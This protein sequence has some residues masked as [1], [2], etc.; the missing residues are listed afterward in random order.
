MT[1]PYDV[2]LDTLARGRLPALFEREKARILENILDPNT[3]ATAKRQ[4]VVTI[5]FEPSAD[6]RTLT[7]TV[8]AVSKLAPTLPESSTAYIGRRDGQPVAV[9]FDPGQNDL[10]RPDVPADVLPIERRGT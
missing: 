6:R 4:I 10:F 2:G 7:N 1:E 5:T 8:R 3:D 9:T